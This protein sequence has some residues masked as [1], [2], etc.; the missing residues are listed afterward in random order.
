MIIDSRGR[1]SHFVQASPPLNV[2]FHLFVLKH[3]GR[4]VSEGREIGDQHVL[5]DHG[6]GS[7]SR[8]HLRDFNVCVRRATMQGE[9]SVECVQIGMVWAVISDY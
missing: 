1:E 7:F 8:M 3:V 2:E 4:V 5:I 9:R 6:C